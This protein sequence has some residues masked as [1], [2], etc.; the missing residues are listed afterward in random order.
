VVRPLIR[1]VR[2]R[3]RC[4]P[5]VAPDACQELVEVGAAELPVEWPG[6]I[7]MLLEGEDLGGEL[8][9]IL[10]PEPA[11]FAVMLSTGSAGRWGSCAWWRAPRGHQ[12]VL[13]GRAE[14][15]GDQHGAEF[16]TIQPGGVRF[17]V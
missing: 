6:G 9:E 2:P 8:A 15:C 14:P 13:G 10:P 5:V 12:R 4:V 17:V 1:Q 3:T 16:V 11:A 7:V